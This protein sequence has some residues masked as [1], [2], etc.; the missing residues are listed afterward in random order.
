MIIIGRN[1]VFTSTLI[2]F[3]STSDYSVW[4]KLTEKDNYKITNLNCF[5]LVKG[6]IKNKK[7]FLW[8]KKIY[9]SKYLAIENE[10]LVLGDSIL[11]GVF[12][13]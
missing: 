11:S 12:I 10:R 5:K 7:L 6:K 8:L 9:A 4:F 2:K 1:E 3:E 13:K